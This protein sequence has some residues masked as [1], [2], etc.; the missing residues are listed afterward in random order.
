M[1]M[2]LAAAFESLDDPRYERNRLHRLTDVLTLAVCTVLGG[3]NTW[4]A[5]A[6]YGRAEED[7]FRRFLPLENGIPSH[8]TF[9]RVFAELDPA[10]FSQAFG[11]WM[12][13]ACGATGP[14][15]IAVDGNSVRRSPKATATGCL[16]PVGAWATERRIALGR[17]SV[18]E[19]GNEI[20][21]IPELLRVLDLAGAIATIDAAGCRVE[22]ARQIRRRGGEYLLAVKGNQPNLLAA[23]GQVFADA[24]AADFEGVAVDQHATV[25]TGHGRVEER[26]ATAI[27]NPV[28]LPAAWPD[29]AAVVPVNRER[30]VN[31]V[32]ATTT[33]YSVNS[34]LGSAKAF[35]GLVR[36]HWGIENGLHWVSDVVF[37]EDDSR[38]RSGHA[39]ANLTMVRK[40]ALALLRR[41]PGKG[42]ADDEAATG[43]LGRRTPASRPSWIF[44]RLMR[45]NPIPFC[46]TATF[47]SNKI[48]RSFLCCGPTASSSG[49]HGG[50]RLRIAM[51]GMWCQ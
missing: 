51:P 4:D 28:G 18:A 8:D 23:V 45:V 34:H 2:P 37:R 29:V 48:E 1:M 9:P 12:A 20:A 3:A 36:G 46:G 43:R 33:Q 41:A 30:E 38:T 11:R 42:V 13:A 31:G 19:G 22:I 50:R 49:C 24:I 40:V 27:A 6:K 35:G 14:V 44:Q 7:F 25:G 47:I 32:T 10:A 16:H 26:Y 17:V 15:P 5:I 39:G 21:A